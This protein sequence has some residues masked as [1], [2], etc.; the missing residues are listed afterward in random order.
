MK[1]AVVTGASSGLGKEF[2]RQIP[3]LYKKLDEIWVVARRENRLKI[4]AERMEERERISV[5]IFAGDLAKDSVYE[6]LA[7]AL[8]ED[9][10]DIRMLVNCAGFGK[11][12]RFGEIPEKEQLSMIDV[13]CRALTRM[14]LVC[15]PYMSGGS[16]I[17]NAASAAAFSPQPGFAVYAAGKAYVKSLS[18]AL[19]AELK[20][21]QIFVTAVC[22]GP[23]DTE[24]FRR[25]GKL[26]GRGGRLGRA[27][28]GAVVKR[29]LRDTAVKRQLSVY[30][31]PM[32]AAGILSKLL[33]DAVTAAV[34]K[35]IN[36]I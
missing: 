22:P 36:D 14:T 27:D 23:V 19:A 20:E 24:F 25:S 26:P 8:C 21:R 18:H 7:S 28:A 4:L 16:R 32:K 11:M 30:G 1:I 29:A 31:A 35:R 10:P 15:L 6:R 34:M 5:R 2:A 9:Q 33:P 13:N 3:H 12:G 17:V